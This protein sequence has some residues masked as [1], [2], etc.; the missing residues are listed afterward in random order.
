I[1]GHYFTATVRQFQIRDD[2]SGFALTEMPFLVKSDTN[3][4]RIV[5]IKV[6]PDGAIYLCDWYN[7]VIGH[8]QASYRDP[9]RDKTHGR[10]WR[11]TAKGRAATK[12]PNLAEMSAAQ[13]LEQLRSP[14]RWTT[15]Q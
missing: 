4:F 7:P 9:N 15:Y 3:A 5:D 11:L 13:L 2:A 6:G 14:D 1:L 8:Y 10:I 12:P